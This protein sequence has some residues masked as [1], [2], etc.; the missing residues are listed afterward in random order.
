MVKLQYLGLFA[1]AVSSILAMSVTLPAAYALM[2]RDNFDDSH[3]TAR[4]L[5]G[6]KICGDHICKPGESDKMLKAMFDHQHDAAKCRAAQQL[7]KK[8]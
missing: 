4:F 7:G 2:Q 8:C 5:G 3:T 1:V 6:V